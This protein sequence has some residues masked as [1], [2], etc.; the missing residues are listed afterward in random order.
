MGGIPRQVARLR[1]PVGPDNA[2][3]RQYWRRYESS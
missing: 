2:K 3:L 1:L